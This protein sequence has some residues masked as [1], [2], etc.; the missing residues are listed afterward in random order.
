MADASIDTSS[1]DVAGSLVQCPGLVGIEE[2]G[3]ELRN[4]VGQLVTG[5]VNVTGEILED[6]IVAVAEHH[7]SSIPERVV[8]AH[9]V[10]NVGVK[11]DAKVVD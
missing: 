1:K 7:A 5:H 9:S 8:E 2:P 10:I 11:V 6:D 4:P 3:S